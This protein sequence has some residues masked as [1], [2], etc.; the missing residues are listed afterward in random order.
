MSFELFLQQFQN[1]HAVNFSDELVQNLF[2][3]YCVGKSWDN[4]ILVYPD[5]SR[6]E[7]GV[8]KDR[9]S[10]GLSV[11]RPPASLEFWRAVL[12]LLQQTPS[13]LYWPGGGPVIAQA[14]VRDHLPP[15]MIKSLGE[16]LLVSTPEQIVEAVRNS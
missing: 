3:K 14:S 9:P 7:L 5:G 12:S 10:A 15:S 11:S 1:S 2:L 16:P 4:F 6:S 13:C 8:V